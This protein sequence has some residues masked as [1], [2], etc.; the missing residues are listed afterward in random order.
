MHETHMRITMSTSS[1]KANAFGGCNTCMSVATRTAVEPAVHESASNRASGQATPASSLQPF[2]HPGGIA[3][4]GASRDDNKIGGAVFASLFNAGFTGMIYPVNPRAT[5]VHGVRAYARLGD[6]PGP[7]DL[8]IIAIPAECVDAAIDECIAKSVRAVIVL[9][10][11]YS[12]RGEDGRAREQ[13]LVRKVRQ[14]GMRLIGPNCLGLMNTDPAV[15]LNASFTN[16]F[17]PEGSVALLSQSGALGVA[18]LDYVQQIG[19]GL[20]TFVSVGN[21]ADVSGNDLLE[22]WEDDERTKLILL[23][24]ESFGNPKKF[25]RIARRISSVKPIVA[26]KSGRSKSGERAVASHTGSLAG[27]D[28]IVDAMFKQTGVI[29]TDTL[30]EMFDVAALLANQPVPRGNR[31]AILTNAGGP[32]I[33][34]ADACEA[35]GLS[36]PHLSAATEA[37]L[38]AALS[39][40]ASVAN[41]ID[42]IATATPRQFGHATRIILNDPLIDSLMILFV[43][44]LATHS[45]AVAAEI[46]AA[47]REHGKVANGKT[48]LASFMGEHGTFDLLRPIPSFRFPE[49]AAAALARA[50]AYGRWQ[51]RPV[52]EPMTFGDVNREELRRIIVVAQQRG[53]GWLNA[54]ETEQ[55]IGAIGLC[56]PEAALTRS[57]DQA[58]AAANRIGYPVALKATSPSIIH[59]TEL[60]AVRLSIRDESELREAHADLAKRPGDRLNGGGILV[61]QMITQGVEYAAGVAED[62]KFG[63]VIMFGSGGTTLELFADVSFRLHPLTAHDVLEMLREV[64]GAAMLRGY[65]GGPPLDERAVRDLLLRT[66]HLLTICPEIQEIDFNPVKVQRRGLTIVDARIRVRGNS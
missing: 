33:M 54:E 41:P 44:I 46:V 57:I 48:V 17:P 1:L 9:T 65:R 66:S 16:L 47:V 8:A 49:S 64:K 5:S 14:A 18:I 28:R 61:Q 63:P 55:L 35:R 42:M 60:G 11:G 10:A 50:T 22:Y 12:E 4:I 20:S 24:L 21:K 51:S 39:P 45:D 53:G 19:L 15:R 32:G 25:S 59:K 30:E 23:Y 43:P 31:V 26:V 29:R 37:A 34:A 27:S 56:Q 7:V 2:F 13:S 62:P 6:V 40:Q 36:V 3:V 58:I 38:R 52:E